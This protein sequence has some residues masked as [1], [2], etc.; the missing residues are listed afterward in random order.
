M[1]NDFQNGK[2]YLAFADPFWKIL[3][4]IGGASVIFR[5]SFNIDEW[6]SPDSFPPYPILLTIIPAL[7]L[8]ISKPIGRIIGIKYLKK[9]SVG[10]LLGEQ[11]FDV[12]ETFLSIISNVASYSRLLAL[13]MA[14]MGLM[15]VIMEMVKLF[16]SIIAIIII[17]ILG[18]LFVILLESVLAAIHALRLTFYEFFSKFYLANG[19]PYK[20]TEINSNYSLIEYKEE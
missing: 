6:F 15:L 5:Y 14:H 13:A 1:L 19:I 3:I 20:H 10:G 17:V 9:E 4:L 11:A 18:N 8:L 12:A 16:N 2:T 7:L